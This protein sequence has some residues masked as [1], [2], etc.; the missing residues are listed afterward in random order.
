M[1]EGVVF[2]GQALATVTMGKA[3]AYRIGDNVYLGKND[4]HLSAKSPF[5][6]SRPKLHVGPKPNPEE[7]RT[8]LAMQST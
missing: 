3:T 2:Y 6:D 5:L 1:V 7:I 4:E 8:W